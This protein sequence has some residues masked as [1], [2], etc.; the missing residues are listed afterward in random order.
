[1]PPLSHFFTGVLLLDSGVSLIFSLISLALP[2]RGRG[3]RSRTAFLHFEP[4]AFGL[5]SLLFGQPKL[6]RTVTVVSE[7]G[8][9]HSALTTLIVVQVVMFMLRTW[10]PPAI[11]ILYTKDFYACRP[12]NV[13]VLCS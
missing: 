13:A 2:L 3:T 8:G 10:S 5:C 12:T 9:R 11:F 6:G 7:E 4:H 1:M